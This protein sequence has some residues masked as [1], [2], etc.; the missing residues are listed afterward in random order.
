MQ[1]YEASVHGRATK[2]GIHVA[3]TCNDCHS[4]GGSAHKILAP[5]FADS[6]INHFNIPK[7][8]GRCHQAVEQDYWEGI[9]GQ[10][11]RDGETDVPVCT[12][13]HG[14]HGILAPSDPRSPVSAARIAEATCARC[15]DSEI[16]NEK[17]GLSSNRLISFVDSYHGLKSKAGDTHVANCASCHGAHRILPSSDPQSTVS[18]KNLQKTCGECH[19]RI[20]ATVASTPIHG[21]SGRGLHTKASEIVA[22]IYQVAIVII[23]GLMA[24]HWLFDLGRQLKDV[25]DRRPQIRRMRTGEVWQHTLLAVSFTVLV[26]SGFALRYDQS[27]LART[28]FGWSGGFSARGVVHRIAAAVFGISVVWHGLYLFTAR[29]RQFLHDMMP[30][31]LDFKYFVNSILHNLGRRDK[32][33]C[34]QRFSYVEKAEYWALVWGTAVM[35]LTGIMLLF[36]NWFSHFL[37][38]GFLDVALTIHFYEA[39]LAFL[40]ILIWHLYSTVFSPKVYPM[41]PAWLTGTMPEEMYA[42]EHPGHLEA[43]RQETEEHL[44]RVTERHHGPSPEDGSTKES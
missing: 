28:L 33:Q 20:S 37:P 38:S 34:I 39:W 26:V 13:C 15:H 10:L 40:A 22:R 32:Q 29:G 14:E 6:S 3:A 30:K 7:T 1:I 17:Y 5:S 43:A 8:C 44:R 2:G 12:D 11:A 41:N 21:V 35:T 36:D 19:P 24:L 27:W 18:V 31:K 4:T 16:L 23:I 25:L 42:E 9:H